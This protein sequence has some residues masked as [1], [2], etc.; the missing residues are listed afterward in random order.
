MKYILKNITKIV[1]SA[2]AIA[3]TASCNLEETKEGFVSTK[4]FYQT[5]AQCY[6]GLNS[7]YMPFSSFFN[8]SYMVITEG[9]TDL[10]YIRSS[11]EDAKLNVS[12]VKPLYGETMW[13]KCYEGVSSQHWFRIFYLAGD[14]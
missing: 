8:S 1:A 9:V 7:C 11:S 3:L 13:K 12:P 5:T 14:S 6:A 2:L 4:D 10:M